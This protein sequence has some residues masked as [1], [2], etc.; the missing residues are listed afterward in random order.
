MSQLTARVAFLMV[1]WFQSCWELLLLSTWTAAEGCGRQG[2]RDGGCAQSRGR[3]R[4]R[5]TDRCTQAHA[6]SLSCIRSVGLVILGIAAVYF[7][8]LSHLN[9]ITALCDII[10]SEVESAQYKHLAHQVAL[11]YQAVAHCGRPLDAYKQ[12]IEVCVAVVCCVVSGVPLMLTPPPPFKHCSCSPSFLPPS[13]SSCCC[14][15]CCYRCGSQRSRA[16]RDPKKMAGVQR[17]FPPTSSSG[18]RAR[19]CVVCCVLCVVCR[20]PCVVCC[21]P[22]VVCLR[23]QPHRPARRH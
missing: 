1:G 4:H 6:L 15:C 22:C 11:L 21:V 9:S 2:E 5:H 8:Q 18:A 3:Y 7:S 14:C 17:A 23:E 20:V 19:A 10:R 13:S 12:A 16:R